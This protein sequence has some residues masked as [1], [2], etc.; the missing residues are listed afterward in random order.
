MKTLLFVFLVLALIEIEMP[1]AAEAA[2]RRNCAGGECGVR[3]V[4][5]GG[6]VGGRCSIFRPFRPQVRR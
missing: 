4:R 2:E 5:Q 1:S 3:A 6:C